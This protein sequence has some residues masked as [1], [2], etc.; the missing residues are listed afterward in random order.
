MI[1][2]FTPTPDDGDAL[3]EMG[4]QSFVET[5]GHLYAPK[6]LAAFLE[7]VYGPETG[8]PAE[9]HDPSLAFRA[10]RDGDRIVAFAKTSPRTLPVA[11]A[12]PGAVELRQLYILRGWQGRGVADTLMLWA[13]DWAR[14]RGAPEMYL[15][16]YMDNPRAQRFY[17]RY[18]FVDI[19]P[20]AFMV[21]SQADEDRIWKLTL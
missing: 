8:L 11:D 9:L 3:A 7:Q 18:G 15:S 5:F 13:L 17:T 20:Y 19:G 6:D 10:A 2:Y 14:G 12:A 4:R 21:G 16:V 1:T